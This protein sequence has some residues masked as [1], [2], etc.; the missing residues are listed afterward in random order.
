MGREYPEHPLIG[1]GAVVLNGAEI[2]LIRRGAS[3]GRG[4]WSVPGGLL[5]VGEGPEEAV[6][7][8]LE[9]EAGLKGRVLGL[10]GVYK[11]IERDAEDRVKYHFI[12]LD[13]LV[14]PIGGSLRAATDAL[15]ARFF[16]L[17][18]A[19][20]LDLTETARELISDL[21]RY[22]PRALGRC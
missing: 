15:E 1:V 10:F 2:L 14:E 20:A 19:A 9:E 12:L 16:Q 8:E 18:E 21:L 5:E 6:V 7:R 13:Y 3:P 4:K 11:Y 22:G 17:E